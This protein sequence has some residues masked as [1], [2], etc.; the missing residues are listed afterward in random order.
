VVTVLSSLQASIVVGPRIYHAMA[1]DRLFPAR[2]ARLHPRSR[3]PVDA[4]AAQGL[5]SCVLLASGTFERLV[6]F[7]TFALCLF[8]I[9]AVAAVFVLRWR[10]PGDVRPFRTPGYPLTPALFV[11]GNGWVL[12]N[13]L[14]TGAREALI[15]LGIV[16][17]G[18]PF[19]RYFR[20]RTSTVA[21]GP[22]SP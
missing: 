10:W 22:E 8:S 6:T 13:L 20:E 21:A 1:E 3:V 16:L 9:V 19:Y 17:T 11:L 15:G 4:L 5:I 12:F 2:L 14:A 18:V 7:T